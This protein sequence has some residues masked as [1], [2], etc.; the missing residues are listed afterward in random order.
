MSAKIDPETEA[1]KK[2]EGHM[3]KIWTIKLFQMK[4]GYCV[5]IE[6]EHGTTVIGRG[7]SAH[8]AYKDA[9]AR[10]VIKPWLES[11]E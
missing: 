11:K 3:K 2:N 6:N 7:K 1:S 4:H 5:R 10:L 8:R 9:E